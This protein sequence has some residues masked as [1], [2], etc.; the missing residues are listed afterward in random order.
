MEMVRA[1][2]REQQVS[3]E[4]RFGH[5]SGLAA[6]SLDDAERWLSGLGGGALALYGLQRRD[7]AGLGFALLGAGLMVHG[8]TGRPSLYR[9]LGLR[10]VETTKGDKRIEVVKSITIQR[11]VE[12]VYRFWRNLEN[13]P[14]FMKHLE[15]VDVLDERRSRWTARAPGGAAVTWDAE[16][17]NEK[18]NELVAWRSLEGAD[19]PNWGIVRFRPAP[20]DRGTEVTVELEYVPVWGALGAALA[21][22]YGEEPAQQVANDLRRL[23]QVLEAGEI[24][25]AEEQPRGPHYL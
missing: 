9:L 21:K 12:E 18:E 16:I 10:T 24:V 25:T 6:A 11:P 14:R 8:V 22:L 5:P 7:P 20:G 3:D 13:L 23:K 4:S 2:L 17:V 1:R 15:R 19:V